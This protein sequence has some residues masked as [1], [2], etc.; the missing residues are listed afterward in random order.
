MKQVKSI[1]RKTY[2]TPLDVDLMKKVKHLA[3]DL[4]RNHNSLIEEALSDLL[5]KY[6]KIVKKPKK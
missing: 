1:I 5:D 2:A 3:V 4:E 6:E